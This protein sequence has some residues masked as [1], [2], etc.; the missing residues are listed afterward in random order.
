MYATLCSLQ[1]YLQEAI[2]THN[3]RVQQWTNGMLL[4]FHHCYKMSEQNNMREKDLF[5]LTVSVHDH[6]ASLLLGPWLVRQNMMWGVCVR[7]KWL[8]SWE[9]GRRKTTWK[10]PGTRCYLSKWSLCDSWLQSGPASKSLFNY[11]FMS[12]LIHW[13]DQSLQNQW[14]DTP[15]GDQVFNMSC[16]RRNF[17]FKL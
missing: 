7:A 17:I 1:Y 16:V 5:W 13:L 14:L 2:C 12:G 11:E 15:S 6:L 9:I 10:G 4:T 8:T 3:L